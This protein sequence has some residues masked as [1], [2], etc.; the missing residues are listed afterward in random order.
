VQPA[1]QQHEARRLAH[2][3]EPDAD[4]AMLF[5]EDLEQVGS[6]RMVAHQEDVHSLVQGAVEVGNGKD[7]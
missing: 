4:A 2:D 3:L 1:S 6:A 5:A 7:A